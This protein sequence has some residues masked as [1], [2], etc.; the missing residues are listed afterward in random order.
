M[1]VQAAQFPR[2]NPALYSSSA[3]DR[4]SMGV[5]DANSAEAWR[6]RDVAFRWPNLSFIRRTVG[7]SVDITG[8]VSLRAHLY[9]TSNMMNNI[10]K[11]KPFAFLTKGNNN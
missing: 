8:I 7:N 11:T 3:T 4:D 5:R 9:A 1:V 2:E 6:V 10:E